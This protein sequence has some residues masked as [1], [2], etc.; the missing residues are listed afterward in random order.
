MANLKNT[1]SKF[2]RLKWS[3][4][5]LTYRIVCDYVFQFAEVDFFIVPTTRE[6]TL[7]SLYAT[8]IIWIARFPLASSYGVF[9]SQ[10]VRF[11]DINQQV[12][13]FINDVK[14]MTIKFLEQGFMLKHLVQFHKFCDKYLIKYGVDISRFLSFPCFY[15]KYWHK[16]YYIVIFYFRI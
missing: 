5:Q 10:H 3:W 14:R 2:T 16:N 7:T 9:M 12:K 6:M 15:L 8:T 11:C 1:F 4:S 13:G